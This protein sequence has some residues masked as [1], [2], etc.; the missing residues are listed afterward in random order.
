[1]EVKTEDHL[2]F[3]Q[4]LSFDN[5]PFIPPVNTELKKRNNLNFTQ[6]QV[7]GAFVLKEKG[8]NKVLSVGGGL[9]V[10]KRI[11]CMLSRQTRINLR[12]AELGIIE[13]EILFIPAIVKKIRSLGFYSQKHEL[14]EEFEKS[15]KG[16]TPLPLGLLNFKNIYEPK[17][18]RPVFSF[19]YLIN[20]PG[21]YIIMENEKIVY[22]GMSAS[23]VS[24][25]LY[26]HF[27]K[28]GKDR[29]GSHYRANYFQT[30]E[31]FEYRAVIIEV[32]FVGKNQTQIT[33]EVL[34]LEKYLIWYLDPLDNRK[35]VINDS[36]TEMKTASLEEFTSLEDLSPDKLPF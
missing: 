12:S 1:M 26:Q 28:H 35:G 7:P 6:H 29:H 33:R 19:R 14:Y 22:V 11:L 32:P 18:K 24:K 16:D 4:T 15:I 34:E 20:V 31:Q 5:I 13:S 25:A 3:F 17:L 21:V 8:T 23:K 27:V 2:N 9:N 10:Y 36:L 30:R